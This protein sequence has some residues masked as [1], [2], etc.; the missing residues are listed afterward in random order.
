M[1][2]LLALEGRARLSTSSHARITRSHHAIALHE[3]EAVHSRRYRG[4][5]AGRFAVVAH[6]RLAARRYY[7]TRWLDRDF[8]IYNQVFY[9]D[10]SMI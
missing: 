6:A 1:G 3:P 8:L 2:C 7:A 4:P 10:V 5:A 9:S